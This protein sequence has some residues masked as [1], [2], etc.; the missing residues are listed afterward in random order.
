MILRTSLKIRPR[1]DSIRPGNALAAAAAL[2]LCG[3]GCLSLRL[4]GAFLLDLRPQGLKLLFE[5]RQ[6]LPRAL[7]A[8]AAA[9]PAGVSV[10]LFSAHCHLQGLISALWFGDCAHWA[11]FQELS[12][13]FLSEAPESTVLTCAAY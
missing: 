12:F 5:L 10:N 7:S 9:A 13:H 8:A 6:G 3:L 1:S 11:H 4:S 2:F